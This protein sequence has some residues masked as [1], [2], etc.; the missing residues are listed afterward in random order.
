MR[1]TKRISLIIISLL[2][3]CV[4]AGSAFAAIPAE[5]VIVGE[6]AYDFTYF[7]SSSQALMA[8]VSAINS[9]D[10]IYVRPNA[11]L[12]MNVISSQLVTDTSILPAVT[13]YDAGGNTT[14]YAAGDG[15][16]TASGP[17]VIATYTESLNIAGTSFGTVAI[18]LT[19]L[20]GASTFTVSYLAAGT[21]PATTEAVAVDAAT[22]AIVQTDTIT[23]TVYDASGEVLETFE[24]VVYGEVSY[25][26]GETGD[27]DQFEVI[28]I[29]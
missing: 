22:E 20:D 7:N 17:G 28:A 5:T 24:D 18:E 21:T 4:M 27:T 6:N 10:P 16:V 14:A 1:L 3:I 9:G 15:D 8:V 11:S 23:I 25:G 19:D 2:L 13:Y 29:Y 26:S 12:T